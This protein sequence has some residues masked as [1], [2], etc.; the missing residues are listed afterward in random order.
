MRVLKFGGSSLGS[1]E[2][3]RAAA[4]VIRRSQARPGS[5]TVVVSAFQGVTDQLI[6][7]ARRA[8]RGEEYRT[9]L[10]ELEARHLAAVRELLP[11]QA[12][13]PLLAQVKI[14][15]NELADLL[16][17]VALTGELTPRVQDAVMSLGE[18][19]SALI[20]AAY[21]TTNGI[22]AERL[23]MRPLV[24]TDAHFGAAHVNREVTYRAIQERFAAHPALQIA[25]G[26]IGS[27]AQGDTTTLGRGGSDYTA[28]LLGAAL[29]A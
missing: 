6:A 18:R 3:I 14:H 10:G 28:A 11:I 9:L 2:T 1:P 27:T 15:V 8:A 7:V 23:D 21:L 26:F 5:I 12:Q 22:A 29:D 20:T 19:F 24:R 17:G 4:Q 25:T 13:S 16:Q